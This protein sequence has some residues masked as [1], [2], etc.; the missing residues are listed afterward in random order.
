MALA[1]FAWLRDILP[2][3]PAENRGDQVSVVARQHEEH[4]EEYDQP[5]GARVHDHASG[6]AALSRPWRCIAAVKRRVRT[7]RRSSIHCGLRRFRDR[8]EEEPSRGDW[9]CRLNFIPR[10][11]T[12]TAPDRRPIKTAPRDSKA[13]PP[14]VSFFF[15]ILLYLL[16]FRLDRGNVDSDRESDRALLEF[17]TRWRKVDSKK[18]WIRLFAEK[19]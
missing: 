9:I 4:A 11:A 17:M 18:V 19:G 3:R 16:L 6:S 7:D 2:A 12:P 1:T 15:Y 5:H 8:I 13:P 10:A 14:F